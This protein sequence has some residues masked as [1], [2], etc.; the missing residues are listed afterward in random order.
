MDDEF[1]RYSHPR[2]RRR[3]TFSGWPVGYTPPIVDLLLVSEVGLSMSQVQFL[4]ECPDRDVFVSSGPL[5][6]ERIVLVVD[7]ME[8]LADYPIHL[9]RLQGLFSRW[10][11]SRLRCILSS[12]LLHT[13]LMPATSP[14]ISHEGLVLED[15]MDIRYESRCFLPLSWLHLFSPYPPFD[16]RC[17]DSLLPEWKDGISS[18][19][20]RYFR[21]GDAHNDLSCMKALEIEHWFVAPLI[22]R[23]QCLPLCDAR[24]KRCEL[25]K[26]VLQSAS[27]RGSS[28][29]FQRH[30]F[31]FL[32][33]FSTSIE[34]SFFCTRLLLDV[35][36]DIVHEEVVTS[37]RIFSSSTMLTRSLA[38]DEDLEPLER[39]IPV[40]VI[41]IRIAPRFASLFLHLLSLIHCIDFRFV[42]FLFSLFLFYPSLD[43]GKFLFSCLVLFVHTVH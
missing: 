9:L 12:S 34:A 30:L 11:S 4:R 28:R 40:Q 33:R 26:D 14:R 35:I 42:L 1:S 7:H 10:G 38:S 43:G 36:P 6:P 8:E 24:S 31:H 21:C 22:W 25:S 19:S 27:G 41:S 3:G 29:W 37:T 32:H 20:F 5:I 15:M 17:P 16:P 13:Y 23:D 39:S 2:E 18:S